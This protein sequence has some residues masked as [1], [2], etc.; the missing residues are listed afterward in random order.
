M[1]SRSSSCTL[2]VAAHPHV[3]HL[4]QL[5]PGRDM[6][7]ERV[8]EVGRAEPPTCPPSPACR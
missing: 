3:A 6:A 8:G 1:C 5:V 4:P 7:L 2:L